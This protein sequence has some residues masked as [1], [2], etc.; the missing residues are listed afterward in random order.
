MITSRDKHWLHT[1]LDTC[2]YAN[3]RIMR[4]IKSI[5]TYYQLNSLYTEPYIGNVIVEII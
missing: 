2:L 3:G 1:C 5:G 4:F